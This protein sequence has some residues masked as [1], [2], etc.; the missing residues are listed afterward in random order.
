M[1]RLF[2]LYP[3]LFLSALLVLLFLVNLSLGSV[4]IPVKDTLSILFGADPE[5]PVWQQILIDFRLTKAMTCVFAGSSLALGGLM[6]QT[7]FRNPLAG[8][9]VLGL[10]SGASLA[11]AILVMTS[12]AALSLITGPFS[13]AFA[14]SVGS[15]LIFMVVL[16]V[17]NRVKDNTS[18]LLIGLM[19]GA[20]TSSVVS[21]LQFT[22][23]SEDQHYF[24]VWTFGNMGGLNWPEVF[25]LG[26]VFLIGLTLSFLLSKPLNAWLLGNNYAQALGINLHRARILIIISTSV[27]AG[28]VTAFCGPIAF[29]G[30]AVPHLARLVIHTTN[31]RVLIPGTTLTGA[32]VMLLC[33]TVAQ[34]PGS[35]LV[36]PINAITSLVG[37]PVVIW[38]IVRS[39]KVRV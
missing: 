8:P 5:N 6:M 21:I 7:L 37:A 19:I 38:V 18:L 12:P 36:L 3:W 2:T 10:S 29:I 31:H 16:G 15:A 28:S 20:A 1:K 33:D 24:L 23:R 4:E 14:A 27:L 9:D 30:L 25:L 11:V 34:L 17:A 26:V 35:S 32:A 39:K 22:S 13:I